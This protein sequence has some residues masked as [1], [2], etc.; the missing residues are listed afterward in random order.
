MCVLVLL[1]P[2]CAGSHRGADAAPPQAEIDEIC[3][4][5]ARSSACRARGRDPVLI[6]RGYT[7]TTGQA[8]DIA[9]YTVNTHVRHICEDA[10]PQRSELLNYLNRSGDFTK[11]LCGSVGGACVRHVSTC[12]WCGDLYSPGRSRSALRQLISVLR[13]V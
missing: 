10:D 4:E 12:F 9:I 8:G 3:S 5:V 1:V 7:R 2:W 13:L 6:A 11:A